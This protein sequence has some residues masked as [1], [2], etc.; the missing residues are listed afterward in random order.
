LYT[1]DDYLAGQVP[2]QR[3]LPEYIFMPAWTRLGQ[4]Y[5][6]RRNFEDAIGIFEE[7]IAWGEAQDPDSEDYQTI[8][9][10]AYYALAAAYYYVDSDS[11]GRP[12]CD[13]AIPLVEKALD[14]YEA[15]RL[16]DPAAL[17]NILR[18]YVLCRDYSNTPPTIAFSFPDGYEEPDVIIELPGTGGDEAEETPEE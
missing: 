2:E 16:E 13:T 12:L 8:P 14:I 15:Q 9:L 7:A 17:T 10:E 1:G 4:V 11:E 3:E 18:V 6:T 5:Y